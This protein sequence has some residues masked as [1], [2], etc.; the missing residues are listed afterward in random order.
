[1]IAQRFSVG[2][3][4]AHQPSPAGTAEPPKE[5]LCC[6][7]PFGTSSFPGANPTLKRLLLPRSASSFIS[8]GCACSGRKPDSYQPKA[9]PWVRVWFRS[10]AGQRPASYMNRAFSAENDIGAANPGRCPGLVWTTPLVSPTAVI[11]RNSALTIEVLLIPLQKDVGNAKRSR[12]PQA[13]GYSQNAPPG[14]ISVVH[15]A[16]HFISVQR[17]WTG[18]A[19]LPSRT[20][21]W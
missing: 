18:A 1:M 14:R 19:G 12:V 3:T 2:I 13:L 21:S 10:N 15:C 20:L 7:G 8:Y 11:L 5:E 9:T 4:T 16:A 17:R 6:S